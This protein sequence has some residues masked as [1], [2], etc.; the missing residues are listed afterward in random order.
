MSLNPVYTNAPHTYSNAVAPPYKLHVKS[1]KNS[2]LKVIDVTPDMTLGDAK[3]LSS[4][5]LALAPNVNWIYAGK[6]LE[7]DTRTLTQLNI[8]DNATVLSLHHDCNE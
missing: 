2:L 7:P 1:I 4:K 3:K 8:P 6:K 5:A